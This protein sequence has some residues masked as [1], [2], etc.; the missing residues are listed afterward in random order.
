MCEVLHRLDNPSG[1]RQA[2]LK[3]SGLDGSTNSS[4]SSGPNGNANQTVSAPITI[5]M[6]TPDVPHRA[7]KEGDTIIRPDG[8]E[9]VLARDSKTG[10]LGFGQ[11][12]G[13]YLGTQTPGGDPV[14]KDFY[15]YA[16]TSGFSD[17]KASGH[18]LQSPIAGQEDTYHWTQEWAAI[19]RAT[20]PGDVKASNGDKDATGL[21]TYS[22]LLGTWSWGGPSC[23]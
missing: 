11:N 13:A 19:K 6:R 5:D 12:V 10:V 16:E 7:P 3:Q 4:S 20:F 14:T 15:T 17:S 2:V 22:D 1:Q 23:G 18:Y 21:W 8:S 9:V